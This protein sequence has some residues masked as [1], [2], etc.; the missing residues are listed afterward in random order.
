MSSF[1]LPFFF[2]PFLPHF[3]PS[4]YSPFSSS[5]SSSLSP[6]LDDSIFRYAWKNN[7]LFLCNRYV[8]GYIHICSS[9]WDAESLCKIASLT[10]TWI[11]FQEKLLIRNNVLNLVIFNC[12]ICLH[13][14]WTEW[15]SISQYTSNF[16]NFVFIMLSS[17][18]WTND[19][20]AKVNYRGE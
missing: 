4:S 6:F 9:T 10:V 17:I 8:C 14:T 11:W 5:S 1:F 16:P 3:I 15:V 18:N 19:G 13:I 20:V 2:S 7:W 12:A